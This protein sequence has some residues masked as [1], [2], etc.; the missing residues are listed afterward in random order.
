[1]VMSDAISDAMSII[2][3]ASKVG[4]TKCVLKPAS[5]LLGNV[6]K[7]LQ[8]EKYIGEFEFV[9][10]GKAGYYN[11]ELSRHINKCG[12]IKPR[13]FVKK[14]DFIKYEKRYLPGQNIGTLVVTTPYGIMSQ[15]EAMKRNVG[16]QLIVYVY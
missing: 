1:M 14:D 12:A 8:K 16:G 6:L 5:K 11:V 9:D 15:K 3:N 2:A 4:K 10:N 7:T 13:H